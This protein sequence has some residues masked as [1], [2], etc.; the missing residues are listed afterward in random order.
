MFTLGYRNKTS[1]TIRAI[2]A[3][4]LGVIL[5][6]DADL[7]IT[8]VKIV[9]GIAVA[10]GVVQL[11]V[12]GSFRALAGLDVTSVFTSAL[13][14]IVAVLLLFNPFSLGLMRITAG[15]CFILYGANELL[16]TPK[17]NKAI[18]DNYGPIGEDRGIDEQ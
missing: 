18:T 12:F 6:F 15:I 17:V 8:L 2:L 5:L 10:F 1:C 11:L 3:I 16:S 7:G 14:I 4:V 9:A 13:V